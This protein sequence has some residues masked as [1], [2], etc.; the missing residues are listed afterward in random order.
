MSPPTQPSGFSRRETQI[1]EV[2]FRSGE[3]SVREVHAQLPDPPSETAVRTMLGLLVERGHVGRRRD[4]RRNLFRATQSR[5]R[6]GR[7]ALER[8]L[9]VFYE[10]SLG[11]ALAAQLSDPRKR[12]SDEEYARLSKLIRDARKRDSK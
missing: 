10:G 11:D 8:V 7:S 3:A 6:A 1:M 9:D 5:Q 12:P 4:G 2:L